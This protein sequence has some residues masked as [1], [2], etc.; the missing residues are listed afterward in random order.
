MSLRVSEG[1][2]KGRMKMKNITVSVDEDISFAARRKAAE[3]KTSV[4]QLVAEYL[5]SLSREDELRAERARLLDDLFEMTDQ[6]SQPGL[7]GPFNR[8]EIYDERLS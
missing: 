6:R 4:S 5:R 8:D 3:Q 2:E 7:A 1:L